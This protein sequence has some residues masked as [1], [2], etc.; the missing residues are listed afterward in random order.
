MLAEQWA[1][2]D[3]L[4]DN[5]PAEN[6]IRLFSKNTQCKHIQIVMKYIAIHAMRSAYAIYKK[7]NIREQTS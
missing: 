6:R 5:Y 1:N 4:G 7:A 3:E 2:A